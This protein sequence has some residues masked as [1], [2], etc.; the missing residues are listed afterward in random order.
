MHI[1]KVLTQ[2]LLDKD[3]DRL[4]ILALEFA[5]L[6]IIYPN[7]GNL[8][9]P[10]QNLL[11]VMH[12]DQMTAIAPA[13]RLIRVAKQNVTYWLKEDTDFADILNDII[14][15]NRECI[16]YDFESKHV[17]LKNKSL[18]VV[19]DRLENGDSQTQMSAAAFYLKQ[20]CVGEAKVAPV[21]PESDSGDR[22]IMNI[23]IM[24][25]DPHIRQQ[26]AGDSSPNQL[27]IE[28]QPEV[29]DEED[30]Y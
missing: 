25:P 21:P 3:P 23:L 6:A 22:P 2:E 28:S 29:E 9:R 8:D 24:P 5:E 27:V 11:L 4:E 16:D 7:F 19:Q 1:N 17:D 10:K 15:T 12:R 26:I 30:T 13:C 18:D 14:Q 20:F